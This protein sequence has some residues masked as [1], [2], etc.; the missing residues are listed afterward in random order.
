MERD[1]A[2]R[3][4]KLARRAG[5]DVELEESEIPAGADDN[6][7]AAEVAYEARD[8]STARA[9]FRAFITRHGEDTRA[10]DAQYFVGQSYLLEDRPATA[11]GELRRVLTTYEDGDRVASALYAMSEAF[12]RLHQCDAARDA[13]DTIRTSYGSSAV[14]GDARSR[15][16]EYRSPPRGYCTP[17][18]TGE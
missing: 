16:R 17:T 13:L 9:L 10:D 18:K 3:M 14:A 5:L 6:Y 11:L 7:H 1:Y 15:A 4:E 12:W 8:F 2:E